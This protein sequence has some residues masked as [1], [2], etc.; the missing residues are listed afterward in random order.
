MAVIVDRIRYRPLIGGE[1][2][3]HFAAIGRAGRPSRR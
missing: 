2:T 3:G 1:L